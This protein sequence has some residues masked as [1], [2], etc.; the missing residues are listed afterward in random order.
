MHL[1][2]SH[3]RRPFPRRLRGF[4][5]ALTAL[6]MAFAAL[7]PSLAGA[8]GLT[9]PAMWVELCSADGGKRVVLDDSSPAGNDSRSAAQDVSKH[10]PFC[11][12]GQTPLALPPAA[13]PFVPHVF[14]HGEFP[15]LFYAAPRP[16]HAWAPALS[17]APPQH[18]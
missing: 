10:C 8:L 3:L 17:R 5:A 16:L 13:Q 7:A 11:H 4:S 14:V 12:I 1:R 2:R 6:M 15:A 18:A 9:S